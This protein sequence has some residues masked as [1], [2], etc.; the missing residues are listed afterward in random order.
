MVSGVGSAWVGFVDGAGQPTSSSNGGSAQDEVSV[1][2]DAVRTAACAS[3]LTEVTRRLSAVA[4]ARPDHVA[5]VSARLKA[6]AAT[7]CRKLLPAVVARC[8]SDSQKEPEPK[9]LIGDDYVSWVRR[10]II[11]GGWPLPSLG[12]DEPLV[13][14]HCSRAYHLRWW[15]RGLAALLALLAVAVGLQGLMSWRWAFVLAASGLWLAFY[16]DRMVAQ[17][18]LYQLH[19][20]QF[21]NGNSPEPAKVAAFLQR[22]FQS[23]ALPYSLERCDEMLSR[24]HFVGAGREIWRTAEIGID[25]EPAPQRPNPDEPNDEAR[26]GSIPEQLQS[27]VDAEQSVPTGTFRDFTVEELYAFVADRLGRPAPSHAPGHPFVDVDVTDVAAVSDSRWNRLDDSAWLSLELLAKGNAIGGPGPWVAR[28]YLWARITSWDGEMSA[29]ILVNFVYE[30]GFLRVTVRPHIMAPLNS[31]LEATVDPVSPL[32][33]RWQ[34]TAWLQALGDLVSAAHR[35]IPN[36]E[37]FLAPEL[38]QG[39]GPVSIRETYS[40]SRFDE[41]HMHDDARRYVQMMQRRVFETVQAFLGHH[42]VDTRAYQEQVT[43]IYNMG[44]MVGGDIS[45]N[46]QNATGAIGTVMNQEA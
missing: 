28:R 8:G 46:V 21:L 1:P 20:T 17:A 41:M 2:V 26:V 29:S 11:G 12:F 45:G 43:T 14:G 39:D 27:S 34:R 23:W 9:V 30:N 42:H 35:L 6:R 16:V 25:V 5:E 36:R 19:P 4:Y 24:G 44:V 33:W 31:A 38:D 32:S 15:R 40:I 3:E 37:I 13:L 18:L 22:R 7:L 10:R